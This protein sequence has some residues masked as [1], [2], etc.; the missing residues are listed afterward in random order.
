MRRIVASARR[1]SEQALNIVNLDDLDPTELL[2][3]VVA[4][5]REVIDDL[6][7]L[8]RLASPSSAAV[9]AARARATVAAG[10]VDLL[11]RAGLVP[12]A[13]EWRV[14]RDVESIAKSLARVAEELGVD[15][16][17]L[18]LTAGRESRLPPIRITMPEPIR[19]A[20]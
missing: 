10:L 15:L 12:D 13:P 5:H 14:L 11:A 1:A 4:I 6:A 20:A 16:A 3:E 7:R 19:A 17:E 8:G 18:E 2:A 9:G